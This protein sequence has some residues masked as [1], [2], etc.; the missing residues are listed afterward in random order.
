[1][2][3]AEEMQKINSIID[4]VESSIKG[5]VVK[6]RE[7]PQEIFDEIFVNPEESPILLD[8]QVERI[9]KGF[10]DTDIDNGAD[11]Y[12]GIDASTTKTIETMSGI[13]FCIANARTGVI[14]RKR[15]TDVDISD[16]STLIIGLEDKNDIVDK[17]SLET[18]IEELSDEQREVR[19]IFIGDSGKSSKGRVKNLSR[20][21]SEI[22]QLKKTLDYSN[23]SSIV[24]IDGSIYPRC[25]IR[26][27]KVEE[28][29]LIS[30]KDV[31]DEYVSCVKNSN[32]PIVGTVK[33]PRSEEILRAYAE[34][35]EVDKDEVKWKD[36]YTLMFDY[37][38]ESS[39]KR[40]CN[41]TSEWFIQEKEY[42]TP[43]YYSD[44]EE[45]DSLTRAF[46]YS[47]MINDDIIL[48]FETANKFINGVGEGEELMTKCINEVILSDGIPDSIESADNTA[49]ISR[50][51]SHTI[52]KKAKKSLKDIIKRYNRDEREYQDDY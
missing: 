14:N 2:L 13:T 40:V 11:F 5:E 49:N 1:M 17:E 9:S 4:K 30:E 10:E 22:L 28:D 48:R 12:F 25:L 7:E 23:P 26:G 34:V 15:S 19:I 38:Q 27:R 41:C 21:K 46:F 29:N 45:E 42:Y 50:E 39:M 33:N 44:I 20:T 37:L 24:F 3:T 43:D 6:D 36:D 32:T 16:K 35:S 51:N 18:E 47:M 52:S 8:K 31:L